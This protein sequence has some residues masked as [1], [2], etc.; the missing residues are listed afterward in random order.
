MALIPHQ[1]T[2]QDKCHVKIMYYCKLTQK[3]PTK[4]TQFI[5]NWC[6]NLLIFNA[7]T[8]WAPVRVFW[9]QFV[10]YLQAHII[11]VDS[12]NIKI[13]AGKFYSNKNFSN[14]K[15][16]DDAEEYFFMLTKEQLNIFQTVPSGTAVN[17]NLSVLN[18]ALLT[19]SAN[20]RIICY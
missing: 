2:V 16:F 17:N 6:I 3:F 4:F 20:V 5:W 12:R 15:L 1:C 10:F 19:V 9:R 7:S 14:L 11:V 8:L 18:T 13:F